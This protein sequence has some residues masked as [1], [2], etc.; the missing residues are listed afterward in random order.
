M[1]LVLTEYV[2]NYCPFQ[3]DWAE[4]YPTF[5]EKP[6]CVACVLQEASIALAPS[7]CRPAL[8]GCPRLATN[9]ARECVCVCECATHG[10]Y[11]PYTYT[12]CRRHAHTHIV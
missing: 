3:R 11:T 2:F 12:V 8:G 9:T 4:P 10:P 5:S 6:S 7:I 1:L